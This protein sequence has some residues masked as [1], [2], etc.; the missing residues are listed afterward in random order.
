V[1][2]K[3]IVKIVMARMT[4]NFSVIVIMLNVV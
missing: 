4:S 1:T 2:E 3:A